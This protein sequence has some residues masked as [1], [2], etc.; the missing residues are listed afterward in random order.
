[1]DIAACISDLQC[2]QTPRQPYVHIDAFL[3]AS[4][5]D[6]IQDV[7][8]RFGRP[9]PHMAKWPRHFET[10]EAGEHHEVHP[11]RFGKAPE[12]CGIIK[13]GRTGKDEVFIFQVSTKHRS[14]SMR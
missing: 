2:F 3:E 4:R 5:Q 8:R 14:W 7:R 1:M 6:N 11:Y 10:E 12:V 13:T 9:H